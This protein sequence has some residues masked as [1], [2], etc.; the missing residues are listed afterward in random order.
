LHYRVALDSENDTFDRFFHGASTGSAAGTTPF[1]WNLGFVQLPNTGSNL[2]INSNV[3]QH[4]NMGISGGATTYLHFWTES[5]SSWDWFSGPHLDGIHVT[6]G[7][8]PPV[9]S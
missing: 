7:N 8:F 5:D 3:Q 4:W 1:G 6:E 2:F 9:G